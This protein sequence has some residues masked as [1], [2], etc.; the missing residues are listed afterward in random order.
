MQ[1]HPKLSEIRVFG[2]IIAFELKTEEHTHYLNDAS[3]H[4]ADYFL[5]KG[6]LLRPLGNI[7]YIL[8][9]YVITKN[10]LNYIYT[11][12]QEFLA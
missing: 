12:I 5:Q 10:Q 9:P 3:L 4:I 6:I 1:S 8:P 7:F 11:C 2:T